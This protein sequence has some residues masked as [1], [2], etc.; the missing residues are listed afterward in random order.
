MNNNNEQKNWKYDEIQNLEVIIWI[1]L[2]A[3][4]HPSITNI[5][6]YTE[7]SHCFTELFIT[8]QPKITPQ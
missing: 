5:V 4:Y 3:G 8:H 2:L 7:I 6:C 1:P